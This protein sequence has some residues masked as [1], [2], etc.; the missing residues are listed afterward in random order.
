MNLAGRI[1]MEPAGSPFSWAEKLI[2]RIPPGIPIV[3]DFHAEA[4]SEKIAMAW[5]LDGKVSAVIGTHTHVQTSDE[6]ILPAGTA[7]ISDIG[8]TGP[9]D[10][11]LGV[12]RK[13]VLDL[14]QRGFSDRFSCAPGPG[15]IEGVCLEIGADGKARSIRRLRINEGD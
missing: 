7:A 12:E 1:F 3:L 11:I 2:A 4:T 8:M 9:R 13:T 5:S 6:R 15:I 14:F 10:G